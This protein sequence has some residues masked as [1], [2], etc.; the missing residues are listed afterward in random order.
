[1]QTFARFTRLQR[2]TSP[3]AASPTGAERKEEEENS[4]FC[5]FAHGGKREGEKSARYHTQRVD[6]HREILLIKLTLI[7]LLVPS[8]CAGLSQEGQW[9]LQ[10]LCLSLL[11][12][13]PFDIIIV[14]FCGGI[15]HI[16]MVIWGH[17]ILHI[18][19]RVSSDT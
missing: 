12:S 8:R 18:M 14:T 15:V 4:F 2:K 10:L 17:F 3:T 19:V 6:I 1:M 13:G 11:F 9:Q 16:S 5:F 7:I